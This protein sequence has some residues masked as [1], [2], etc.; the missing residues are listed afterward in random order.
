[1]PP[2]VSG[3]FIKKRGLL[4]NLPQERLHKEMHQGETPRRGRFCEKNL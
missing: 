3:E 1:M 4:Q 2:V